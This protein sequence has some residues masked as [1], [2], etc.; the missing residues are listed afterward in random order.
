V[1]DGTP[2]IVV[3]PSQAIVNK[4]IVLD[5]VVAAQPGWLVLDKIDAQTSPT[6][7]GA[8]GVLYI[9]AG[10]HRNVRVPVTMSVTPGDQ[11]IVQLHEDQG[12]AYT[13]EYPDGPDVPVEVNGNPVTA[14]FL[15]EKATPPQRLPDTGA[16]T[17][18][19][20]WG[21][22][23]FVALISGALL[24]RRQAATLRATTHNVAR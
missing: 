13:Y 4:S 3:A 22:L 18:A 16:G 10:T 24:R 15:V 23:A 14:S 20:I 1:A 7:T 2:I 8:G 12:S 17:R 19:R 5:T 21:A 11:L 9:G 6:F